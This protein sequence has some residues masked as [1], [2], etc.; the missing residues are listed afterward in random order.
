MKRVIAVLCATVV[1]AGLQPPASVANDDLVR[2]YDELAQRNLSPPPLVPT[3]VPRAV[4]PLATSV[5]ELRPDVRNAY[6]L[7]FSHENAVEERDV[8]VVVTGGD[9]KSLRALVK[10]A[11]RLKERV[12]KTRVRGRAGYVVTAKVGKKIYKVLA[13]AEGGV[14]H[15]VETTTPRKVSLTELRRVAAG[16]EP[17]LESYVGSFNDGGGYAGVVL[18]ATTTTVSVR[19]EWGALCK[20]PD[21]SEGPEYTGDLHAALVPRR[22]DGSFAFDIAGRPFETKLPWGGT[23]TGSLPAGAPTVQLRATGTFDGNTCEVGPFTIPLAVP[24]IS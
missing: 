20:R 10:Q 23:V 15:T 22:P 12:K 21:G 2:V 16:L 8:S 6:E 3:S 4:G 1:A 7:E 18:V 17:L 14:V 5:G 9:F 11:R 13:W 24:E 19:G